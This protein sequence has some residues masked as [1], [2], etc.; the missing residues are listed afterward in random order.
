MLSLRISVLSLLTL[1]TINCAR[2]DELGSR[3]FKKEGAI[4]ARIT[5]TNLAGRNLS[6]QINQDTFTTSVAQTVVSTNVPRGENFTVTIAAQPVLPAQTCT[7]TSPT[8]GVASGDLLEITLSCTTQKFTISG[9]TTGYA[10]SGLQVQLNGGE[11][12]TVTG[13]SFSFTTLVDDNSTYNVQTKTNPTGPAQI[14]T[15]QKNVGLVTGANISDVS[16]N[17]STVTYSIGGFVNGLAAGQSVTLQV[18]GTQSTVR[19][20]DG[21]FTFTNKLADQT[22]YQITVLTQPAGQS[23]SVGRGAGILNGEGAFSALIQCSSTTHTISGNLT[24]LTGGFVTLVSSSGEYRP[25]TANGAFVFTQTLATGTDYVVE[26]FRNPAA[27]AQACTV[28]NATGTISANVNNINV[29]CASTGYSIGGNSTVSGLTSAGLVLRLNGS[30]ETVVPA[31]ATS[32]SFSETVAAGSNYTVTIAAQPT[33]QKCTLSNASG[34]AG[35]AVTD[36]TVSCVNGYTVGGTVTGYTGSNLVLRNTISGTPLDL[37]ISANSTFTFPDLLVGGDTYSVSVANYPESPFQNCSIA[38][39]SGTI[40]AANITN[41]SITCTNVTLAFTAVTSNPGENAGAHAIA[42]SLVGT[43][44]RA[45]SVQVVISGGS[46]T[47]MLDYTLAATT[48]SWAAL[49]TPGNVV[50]NILDDVFNEGTETIQIS[51]VN[52]VGI[53][54]GAQTTHT[55]T[56]TD[57]DAASAVGAVIT[58]A[59]YYD[60]DRNG[61]I[62][63]VKVTFDQAVRD[64][65]QVGWINAT[66]NINVS[67]QW[68]I[69]GYSGVQFVP[70]VCI[71]RSIPANGNCADGGDITDTVDNSVVW[72]KFTEGSV[73]DTGATPNLTGVDVTLKTLATSPNDCYVYTSGADCQTVTSA[74]FGTGAVAEADKA[75]PVLAAAWSDPIIDAWQL[76]LQFSEAVDLS[77]G[78]GACAGT[79]TNAAFIYNNVSNSNTSALRSDFADNDGCDST[80]GNYY[81]TPRVNAAFTHSDLRTDTVNLASAFYDTAGNATFATTRTI[82]YDPNIELYYP[83][84]AAAPVSDN[85]TTVYDVSGHGR[86]GSISGDAKLVKDMGDVSNQA[87]QFDGVGDLITVV[88]YKGIQGTAAR[89]MTAWIKADSTT[90]NQFSIFNQD[91]GSACGLWNL[92]LLKSVR[93]LNLAS[94]TCSRTSPGDTIKYENAWHHVAVTYDPIDGSNISVAKLY[95]D[96]IAQA[97]GG[98]AGTLNTATTADLTIGSTAKGRF[99]EMRVYSRALTAAEIRKLAT[100]VPS[101][102][103]AQYPL[104]DNITSGSVVDNSGNGNNAL[105]SGNPLPGPDRFGRVASAYVFDGTGDL[106]RNTTANSLSGSALPRTICAWFRRTNMT[107]SVI[108]VDTGASTA[109]VGNMYRIAGLAAGQAKSDFYTTANS[110][111]TSLYSINNWSHVCGVYNGSTNTVYL[112][113]EAG[114][115]VAY[116]AT[117]SANAISLGGT[118]DFTN[119]LIGSLDDVQV[120]NRALSAGEVKALATEL[121]RGLV[122]Y[123]PLDEATS[124]TVSDYSGSGFT[125]AGSGAAGPQNTPQPTSD[126][127]GNA[128]SAMNFDGNDDMLSGSAASILPSGAATRTGCAWSLTTLDPG[129]GNAQGLMAYGTNSANQTFGIYPFHSVSDTFMLGAYTSSSTFFYAQVPGNGWPMNQWAHYCIIVTGATSVEYYMNGIKFNQSGTSGSPSVN[130]VLSL[131]RVGTS[132]SGA[133]RFTGKIDDVRVYNRALSLAEIRELS[134]FAPGQIDNNTLWLDAGR[135]VFSDAGTTLATNAQS[136]QQWND[137]SMDNGTQ[138][139]NN[140]TQTTATNRPT[141]TSSVATLGNLP[142][143]NFDGTNDFLTAGSVLGSKLFNTNESTNFVVLRQNSSAGTNVLYTWGPNSNRYLH[144]IVGTTQLQFGQGDLSAG[145]QLLANQ[146]AGW[147]GNAQLLEM[148]RLTSN[149]AYINVNSVNK[150]TSTITDPIDNSGSNTFNIS[151]TSNQFNGDIAEIIIYKTG[152]TQSERDNITCYLSKKYAI[153]ASVVCD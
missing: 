7:L 145:G 139:A 94:L 22:E 77:A 84:D 54:L 125:L 124:A 32:F 108:F 65:S 56:I 53:T 59:E 83:M 61:K 79:V 27:P 1:I 80:N 143:I 82:S 114:P 90:P 128:Q 133:S 64:S 144:A 148:T 109:T 35:A 28:T 5:A 66:T 41:V 55:V 96:G 36:V 71:D 89:T 51:L 147:A 142:A 75:E 151:H 10:G 127:F 132:M 70:Q 141:W 31:N 60:A 86:N 19:S 62:D 26:V 81:I 121:D 102:L 46:A 2:I 91:G 23:C 106:L 76:R 129:N 33:G 47:D 25:L 3:F 122:A 17:C 153:A 101:G 9:M 39:G 110:D 137:V 52:P 111:S 45:G 126:R 58:A 107:G 138:N 118:M 8:T 74:D 29:S 4:T 112:N 20:T 97:A 68:L 67:T 69:A 16:I 30:S 14:C 98:V 140:M 149:A 24:G 40:A 92:R 135:A 73:Y 100:K 105:I 134:G 103:V 13:S 104:E 88:G 34:I 136:V 43:T 18:N 87:Y 95:I 48:I 93:V 146:P 152:L 6:L 115:A 131:F 49:A 42:L 50:V 57:N 12:V 150:L 123:F 85:G 38:N 116:T 120:Y 44:P 119:L 99:D 113:G 78:V 72:L 37:V 15:A 117:A 130:T 63:H 11:I 21:F